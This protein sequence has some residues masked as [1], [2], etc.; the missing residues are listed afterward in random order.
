[1]SKPETAPTPGGPSPRLPPDGPRGSWLLGCMRQLQRDPL[2]LY[3]RANR[4]YGH[5]VR[6]R[7]FPGVYVYLLTHPD[8]I[9]HVLQARPGRFAQT[10][11]PLRPF[12]RDGRRF[13]TGRRKRPRRGAARRPGRWPRRGR[14]SSGR[15]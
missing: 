3:T 9:E 13:P 1:M 8:A 5:Y 14:S 6:I 7:A 11:V 2:G 15:K 4:E 12:G 10:S